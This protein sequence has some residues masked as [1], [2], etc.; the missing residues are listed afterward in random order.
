[1]ERNYRYVLEKGPFAKVKKSKVGY[2]ENY[3]ADTM[4]ELFELVSPEESQNYHE[5][6]SSMAERDLYKPIKEFNGLD[7][8]IEY[9][10]NEMP[11]E[12]I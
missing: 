10:L 12:L 8:F 2:Y 9:V 11:E 7:G 6:L 4:S 3:I 1:M 5:T